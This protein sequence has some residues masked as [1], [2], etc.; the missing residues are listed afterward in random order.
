M[1]ERWQ[2]CLSRSRWCRL[3]GLRHRRR[4]SK[5]TRGFRKGVTLAGIREHQAAFQSFATAHGGTRASGTD[6]FAESADYVV[7]RMEAAG[8]DVTRQPFE[9]AFFQELATPELDQV[10]DPTTYVPDVDF[11]TM[12]YSGSG[13]PTA[14][15]SAV[16]IIPPV[17]GSTSGCEDADFAGFTAGHIAL[18]QRGTC[19]FVDKA[20]NAQEAGAAGVIIMNEGNTPG[21]SGLL[22]GTLGGPGIRSPWSGSRSPWGTPSGAESRTDQPERRCTCS[23]RRSRRTARRRT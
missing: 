7:E 4:V 10:T 15:L 3:Q 1:P 9:F 2:R 14:P 6:G 22:E 21:R 19:F 23:P 11:A 12:D 18:V 8:F 13:D 20:T 17:G 5:F 16:D